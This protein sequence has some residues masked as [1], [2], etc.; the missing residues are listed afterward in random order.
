MKLTGLIASLAVASTATAAAV[1]GLNTVK[2]NSTVSHLDRVLD[3][4]DSILGP[5]TQEVLV[6][7]KNELVGIR[8]L[9]SDVV[10]GVVN[11]VGN[12]GIVQDV[13][14]L[15]GNVVSSVVDVVQPVVN[16]DGVVS[17]LG[18]LAHSLVGRIQ[19]GEV[20][21]AG[22]ENLLTAL[23]GSAGLSNLNNVIAEAA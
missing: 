19:S 20:D 18:D 6:D 10:G 5:D 3:H 4:V 8:D 2:L 11:L 17:D 21:A 1:P 15:A 7:T 12:T 22:L 9:L 16:V 14:H 23:G 13:V